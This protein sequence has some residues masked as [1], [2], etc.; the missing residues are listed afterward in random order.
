MIRVIDVFISLYWETS[1]SFKTTLNYILFDT[2]WN[3]PKIPH[4]P[5][6][7]KIYLKEYHPAW[8]TTSVTVSSLNDT[9]L[10][11]YQLVQLMA[12]S[13]CTFMICRS[14]FKEIKRRNA[15]HFLEFRYSI[16]T[17]NSCHS[18]IVTIYRF[19]NQFCLH[20]YKF[21]HFIQNVLTYYRDTSNAVEAWLNSD[22]RKIIT[23]FNILRKQMSERKNKVNELRWYIEF[24]LK[25]PDDH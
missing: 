8:N 18:L 15:W 20:I 7:K 4:W 10:P 25:L 14:D 17:N 24:I 5:D 6:H 16:F 21:L 11:I 2:C 9:C 23:M 12:W 1:W 19:H 3:F 13:K 22:L